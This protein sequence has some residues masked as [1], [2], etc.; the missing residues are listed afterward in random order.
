MTE[1]LEPPGFGVYIHWPFCAA[2]CPYC[3]FNSHVRARGVDQRAYARALSAEIAHLAALAPDRTVTSIFFGGGT[4]SL[5]EP[6]TVETVLAAIAGAWPVA[7]DVEITLEA[8]PSSAEAEKFAAFAR[9]GVNRISVGVQALDDDALAGLG[10]LHGS[11]EALAAIDTARARFS[12]VSFD[13]IY[14]RPGQ[15][16]AVWADE[17]GR[18]LA[19]APDHLSLYQLT[20]E[21]GTP[22]HALAARGAL[23]LPEED[24]ARDMLELTWELCAAHGLPAY[25][26]SNHARP[27]AECRHNLVYWRGQDYAGAG[28]GAH[29][30][31][32]VGKGRLAL[33]AERHPGRWLARVR[34]HGHG[35]VEREWLSPGVQAQEY[36]MMG[37]RLAEGISRNRYRALAGR[38]LDPEALSE[39][40][41]AGLVQITDG[42]RRLRA[43][44]AGRPVLD[45]LIRTLARPREA[46]LSR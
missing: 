22:F 45:A 39:L 13:L 4:P 37:L 16:A 12:R 35:L 19:L 29:G 42:G 17:L 10:R 8:N 9:A 15:S 7:S 11:A 27:G 25:E 20:I 40:S 32:S 44:T 28:P 14:G 41:Q 1:R 36:L 23:A 43:T 2:K 26:I 30:R 38:D 46:A 3:D 31:L 6:A 34:E 21:P 18:A 33:A 5:M 24:T